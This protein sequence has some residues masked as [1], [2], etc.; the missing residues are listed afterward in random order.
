MSPALALNAENEQRAPAFA[1]RET[2][3]ETAAR[4]EELI[5]AIFEW[6]ADADDQADKA[7]HLTAIAA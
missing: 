5:R 3:V 7:P 2:P 6:S 1:I 4:R